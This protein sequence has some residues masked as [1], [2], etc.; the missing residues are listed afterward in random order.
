MSEVVA[1]V[2]LRDGHSGKTRLAASF[3]PEQRAR[4]ISGMANHV[5]E[6]LLA[7][8]EIAQVIV[9]TR[10]ADFAR[11][12][13]SADPRVRIV[14][15]PDDVVGLNAAIALGVASAPDGASALVMHADLPMVGTDDIR[16][17]IGRESALAIA[18]DRHRTGTNALFLRGD[19]FGRGFGFQFGEG[20]Y[21]RHR[22]EALRCGLPC[23]T[24]IQMGTETDLDTIGDWDSLPRVVRI[25]LEAGAGLTNE[26]GSSR[27][28]R[29]D[30]PSLTVAG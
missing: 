16:E 4:L 20:S 12:S 28:L 1:I 29:D 7:V 5:I 18:P 9:V 19:A 25:S 15:Q 8:P 3:T 21:H 14:A 11:T 24:V 17:L 10:D 22:A 2:P 27:L 23:E 30:R 13:L 26:R 6:T